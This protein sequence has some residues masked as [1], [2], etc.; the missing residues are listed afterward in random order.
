M[1]ENETP[2]ASSDGTKPIAGV[3]AVVA[4]IAGM[5]AIIRPIH[6][7][8]ESQ[9]QAMVAVQRHGWWYSIDSTDG[10]SKETFQIVEAITTAR[11]AD[12]VEGH[13]AMPV[14]TVPVSR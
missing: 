1:S 6:N 3:L 7:T 12:T 13:A 14:L 5:A 4:V 11:I 10:Q 9:S 2:S 8:V